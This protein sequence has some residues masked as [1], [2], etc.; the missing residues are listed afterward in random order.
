MIIGN[1]TILNQYTSPVGRDVL[2]PTS[3][4]ITNTF[5][6]SIETLYANIFYVYG[7]FLCADVRR[8]EDIPTYGYYFMPNLFNGAMAIAPYK[9]DN[10]PSSLSILFFNVKIQKNIIKGTH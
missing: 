8:E 2:F 4:Y 3:A 10:L 6:C 5:Y 7:L 1:L 9:H